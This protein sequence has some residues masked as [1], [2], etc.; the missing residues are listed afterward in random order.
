[1]S[2][3]S[4]RDLLKPLERRVFVLGSVEAHEEFVACASEKEMI[5][6]FCDWIRDQNPDIICG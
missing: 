6:A 2:L 3:R 5:L 4:T 1:M